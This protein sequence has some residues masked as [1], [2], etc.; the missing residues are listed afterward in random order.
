MRAGMLVA[1]VWMIAVVVV[2]VQ[3]YVAAVVMMATTEEDSTR[4]TRGEGIKRVATKI[5][6]SEER[7][8]NKQ[9]T[10]CCSDQTLHTRPASLREGGQQRAPHRTARR[11]PARSRY[12]CSQRALLPP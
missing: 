12:H 3:V 5:T 1:V 9:L 4:S 11:V 6:V 7:K 10:R 2:L 8:S